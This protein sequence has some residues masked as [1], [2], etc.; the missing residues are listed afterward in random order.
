MV[1]LVLLVTGAATACASPPQV[2]PTLQPPQSPTGERQPPTWERGEGIPPD[3]DAAMARSGLGVLLGDIE[4][5]IAE[6]WNLTTE[7]GVVVLEVLPNSPAAEAGLE[8]KDVILELNGHQVTSAQEMRQALGGVGVGGV[9]ALTILRGTEQLDVHVAL[10]SGQG[11]RGE[12]GPSEG[13]A[14][15]GRQRQSQ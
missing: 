8:Q 1:A 14:G 4:P 3:A 9:L 10:G 12:R 13:D 5:G 2:T 11:P 7:S 15:P 6:R